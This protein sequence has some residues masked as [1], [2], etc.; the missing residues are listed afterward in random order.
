MHCANASQKA[1]REERG[2]GGYQPRGVADSRRGFSVPVV[3]N[4]PVVT[5][6]N[7]SEDKGI[8]KH[9]ARPQ[10]RSSVGPV[11]VGRFP[12]AASSGDSAVWVR[13]D[14]RHRQAMTAA[15]ATATP[16]VM[17]DRLLQAIDGQSNVSIAADSQRTQW[18]Q[19]GRQQGREDPGSPQ[20]V[21]KVGA[22]GVWRVII[23]LLISWLTSLFSQSYY[24]QAF[25]SRANR[26]LLANVHVPRLAYLCTLEFTVSIQDWR[27]KWQ[28]RD[29][30][31]LRFK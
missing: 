29:F 7:E 14:P 28:T 8:I 19:R 1:R 10:R 5:A 4:D 21:D 24:R 26:L 30:G 23:C 27:Q 3:P 13:P 20:R 16:Q 9:D 6:P 2:G 17:R 22:V 12:T 18:A 31:Q 25:Q 15:T 11:S